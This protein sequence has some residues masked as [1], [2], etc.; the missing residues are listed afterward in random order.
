MLEQLAYDNGSI[1]SDSVSDNADSAKFNI[2]FL[3]LSSSTSFSETFPTQMSVLI[4]QVV[5][6]NIDMSCS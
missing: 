3:S 1:E 4:W 5:I 6:I 2:D